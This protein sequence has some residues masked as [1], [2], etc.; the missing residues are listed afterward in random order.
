MSPGEISFLALVV[1]CLVVFAASAIW[2]RADYV[3][4]RE[5]HP[6]KSARGQAQAAE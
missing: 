4:F 2:L 3:R 1:A 6:D 5:R